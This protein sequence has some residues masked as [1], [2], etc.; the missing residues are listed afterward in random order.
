MQKE[1]IPTFLNEQPKVIFGR[2]GRE[3]LIIV[4][5]IVAGYSLWGNIQDFISAQWWSVTSIIIA[6]IPTIIAFIV[7]LFPIAERPIEEW[8]MCWFLYVS[9]PRLYIY[10][11]SESEPEDSNRSIVT[12][13]KTRVKSGE[14]DNLLE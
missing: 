3:L 8:V 5:G 6:V 9:M 4:C 14:D 13:Q 1:E 12:Q 11:S 7:A 10:K 2:T